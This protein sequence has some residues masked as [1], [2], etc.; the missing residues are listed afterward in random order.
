MPP[1]GRGR[2][3]ATEGAAKKRKNPDHTHF[4]RFIKKVLVSA[5]DDKS[6]NIS[7]KSMTIMNSVV[8]DVFTM[9]A[10]EASHLNKR[11]KSQTVSGATIQS[12]AKLCLPGELARLAVIESTKAVAA[13]RKL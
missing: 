12:A 5:N 1:K 2:P 9:L 7:K 13:Y 11:A 8:N 3:A 4:G 10:N 6:V